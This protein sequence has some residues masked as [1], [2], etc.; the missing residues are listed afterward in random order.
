[1][2]QE[3]CRVPSKL[4]DSQSGIHYYA[5]GAVTGEK[6]LIDP[7]LELGARGPFERFRR[8]RFVVWFAV[9][10]EIEMHRLSRFA[11]VYLLL[12]VQGLK[13][14]G[15]GAHRLRNSQRQMTRGFQGVME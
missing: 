12:P 15:C 8:R 14:I 4:K 6:Q 13:Q 2:L 9:P 11:R 10:G 5:R 1:M 3:G 7:S